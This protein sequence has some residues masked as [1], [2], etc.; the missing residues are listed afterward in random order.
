[1]L[2]VGH[3][4]DLIL[5]VCGRAILLDCG[6]VAADGPATEMLRDAR[7]LESHGLELPLSVA[8]QA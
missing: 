3:D 5:D 6:Q 2:V 4:L 8:G 7:L 1:M